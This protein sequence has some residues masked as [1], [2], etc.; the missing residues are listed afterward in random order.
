MN[1]INYEQLEKDMTELV[2]K[3]QLT[4]Q[5]MR[6]AINTHFGIDCTCGLKDIAHMPYCKSVAK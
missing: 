5:G 2:T 6:Y 3:H 4:Y 1:N